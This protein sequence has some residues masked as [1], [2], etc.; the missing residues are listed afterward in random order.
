MEK[1]QNLYNYSSN[2]AIT[3]NVRKASSGGTLYKPGS[4]SG[5]ITAAGFSATVLLALDE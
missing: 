4:I 2:Q 5:T 1:Y 3:G